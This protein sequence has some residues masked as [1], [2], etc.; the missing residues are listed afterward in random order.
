M[1]I[2]IVRGYTGEYSDQSNWLVKAF[3]KEKSAKKLVDDLSKLCSLIFV[4]MKILGI[5]SEE[6]DQ[7]INSSGILKL[8]PGFLMDYTGTLYT[9]EE[10]ELEE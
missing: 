7:Y 5:H 4:E 2:Y 8:D 10:I 1:K 9:V 6:F 3:N